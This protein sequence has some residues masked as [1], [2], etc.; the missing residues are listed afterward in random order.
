MMINYLVA[1]LEGRAIHDDKLSTVVVNLE[2][3]SHRGA[4]FERAAKAIKRCAKRRVKHVAKGNVS[5]H[6]RTKKPNLSTKLG[7]A[8]K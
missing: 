7:K 5:R 1:N 6:K 3:A 8:S 2:A 4:Q